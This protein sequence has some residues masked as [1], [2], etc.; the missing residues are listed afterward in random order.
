MLLPAGQVLYLVLMTVSHKSRVSS[1]GLAPGISTEHV[2]TG[3][4]PKTKMG[5]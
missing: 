4:V 2:L 5:L 1:L 3:V